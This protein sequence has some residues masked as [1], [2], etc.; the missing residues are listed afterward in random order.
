MEGVRFRQSTARNP[1][2]CSRL[3]LMPIFGLSGNKI[4][5]ARRSYV[6]GNICMKLKDFGLMMQ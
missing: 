3:S 2:I 1:A 6:A 5:Y 4:D